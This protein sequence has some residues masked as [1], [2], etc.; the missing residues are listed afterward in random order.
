MN[1]AFFTKTNLILIA[2]GVILLVAGFWFLA[3]PP[4]DGFISLTVAPLVLTFAYLVII[5]L[6]LIWG[7]SSLEKSEEK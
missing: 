4:V 5:P 1:T 2:L 3:M 7:K 6:G